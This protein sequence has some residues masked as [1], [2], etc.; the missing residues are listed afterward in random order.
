MYKVTNEGERL[1]KYK[2]PAW[3]VRKLSYG[4][5]IDHFS[6]LSFMKNIKRNRTTE[7]IRELIRV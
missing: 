3:L 1:S 6:F 5:N 2:R 7:F 4:K